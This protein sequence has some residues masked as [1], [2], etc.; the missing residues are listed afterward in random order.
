MIDFRDP[1][2]LDLD[3]TSFD[4]SAG[5]LVVSMG[6]SYVPTIYANKSTL[7]LRYITN[8]D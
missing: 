1:T 7:K 2:T 3:V 4:D 6:F 5:K 8:D